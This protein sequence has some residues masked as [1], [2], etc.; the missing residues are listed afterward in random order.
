MWRVSEGRGYFLHLAD[1]ERL[2]EC[3]PHVRRD[4]VGQVLRVEVRRKG[5][6]GRRW[7]GTLPGECA[8]WGLLRRHS[9]LAAS[10]SSSVSIAP[11]D[12]RGKDANVYHFAKGLGSGSSEQCTDLASEP[13][14]REP[15][16]TISGISHHARAFL[17]EGTRDVG[18]TS[19]VM[20]SLLPAS[21]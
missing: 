11:H 21:N 15:R 8:V 17:R 10:V 14:H 12:T 2:G 13:S 7:P 9:R 4:C 1:F 5:G 3:K 6:W 18:C 16:C 19:H 20:G